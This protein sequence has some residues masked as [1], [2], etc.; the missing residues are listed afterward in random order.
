MQQAEQNR[1]ESVTGRAAREAAVALARKVAESEI[2]KEFEVA[3]AAFRGDPAAQKLFQD[4]QRTNRENRLIIS[5]S[6]RD[7]GFEDR[8]QRL[9][10]QLFA[11]PTY[12][13]Y[14][15]A[16]EGLL[17]ALKDLNDYLTG[18]LGFDF[19]DLAKPAGGCC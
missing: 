12:A 3:S 14:M 11:H 19:A 7:K 8:F 5:W 16:Q 9:E 6:G 2:Y 18:K 1:T 17:V 15:T 10:K 4:Y 13:R